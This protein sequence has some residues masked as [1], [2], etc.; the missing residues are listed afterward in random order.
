[1]IHSSAGCRTKHRKTKH[2]N[3]KTSKQR[4]KECDITGKRQNIEYDKRP[5]DK[6]SKVSLK[7]HDKKVEFASFQVWQLIEFTVNKIFRYVSFLV[8]IVAF[9]SFHKESLPVAS[10]FGMRLVWKEARFPPQIWSVYERVINQDPRTNNFLEGWH[11]RFSSIVDVHHSDIYKFLTKLTGEQAHTKM[12]RREILRGE[13]PNPPKKVVLSRNKRLFAVVSEFEV[14]TVG[15]QYIDYL[16]A[17]AYN[18]SYWEQ[19]NFILLYSSKYGFA[20]DKF[21]V[22]VRYINKLSLTMISAVKAQNIIFDIFS[23]FFRDFF[24]DFFRCFSMVFSIFF[25]D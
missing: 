3:V 5:K 13:D 8:A 2:L 14:R 19:D 20:T 9:G 4:N 11:R 18:I 16:S 23:M 12:C 1:M 24:R 22:R 25:F 7:K 15:N 21:H 6:I 17:I 10:G